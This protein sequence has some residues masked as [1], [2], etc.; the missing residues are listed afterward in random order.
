ME[1]G[2]KNNTVTGFKPIITVTE[3][4]KNEPRSTVMFYGIISPFPEQ[5]FN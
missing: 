1:Q 2:V 5:L 4:I 3:S